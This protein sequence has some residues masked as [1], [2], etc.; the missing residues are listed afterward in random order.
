MTIR[1]YTRIF[2]V[3][4]LS[5]FQVTE[6]YAQADGLQGKLIV[7]YQGWFGC[8]N[9][10]EDNQNWWHWFVNQPTLE[11]LTVD[12]LPDVTVFSAKDL[13]DT[14]LPRVDGQGTV[15]LFSS[16][17]ANVVLT[18]FRWMQ[19]YG[20]DVAAVQRFVS[21]LSNPKE[22]RRADNVLKNIMLAA[23]ANQRDFFVVYDVS[24][25]NPDTVINDIRQDWRYLVNQIKITASPAY[26][27]DK[28]KP[29]LELW[30]FGFTDRPG[31]P[32]E[33]MALQQD[34]KQGQNQ[35]AA[36]TLIGG[37]PSYWR[38]LSGDSKSQ[39]GWNQVYRNYDVI[40]PW[41]VG[42]FADNYGA[43]LFF[44]TVVYPDVIE[45]KRL[46]LQYMP[47]IFPGFSWHNLMINH[48]NPSRA[49]LN[50]I[51]RRCGQF[52]QRQIDNLLK[53]NINSL[54]VAMFDEVDEATAMFPVEN[55]SGVLPVGAKMVYLNQDGCNLP[56]DWYLQILK[57]ID[58][59]G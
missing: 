2:I 21:V 23:Q 52:I 44:K 7:G 48:H 40:S 39:I 20:I 4:L 31:M 8:P 46:G 32:D 6:V 15:K 33:V 51:P 53:L 27:K 45:A 41:T 47:V 25:A 42:R 19:D 18:H 55:L 49:I 11:S 9:D 1:S 54:Y 30:G 17:N 22:K 28:A 29:L 13:C 36:V 12:M 56:A 59:S 14:G 43:D 38:S 35:L 57:N 3:L 24:G 5:V 58:I 34:L 37:V 16:Q 26:L 10:F 50:Q